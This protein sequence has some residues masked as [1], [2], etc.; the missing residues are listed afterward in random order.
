MIYI[1]QI[2]HPT[3]AEGAGGV[4]TI[5]FSSVESNRQYLQECI[6]FE[7]KIR[8]KLCNFIVLYCSP[9]QSQDD[10]ET[11]LKNFELNLY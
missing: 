10:F 6:N 7:M 5:K 3:G 2:T 9:S 4:S 11:F 8:K 1:E